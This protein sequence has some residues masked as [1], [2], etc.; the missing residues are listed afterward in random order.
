MLPAGEGNSLGNGNEGQRLTE[1]ESDTQGFVHLSGQ[2]LPACA[3]TW[4]CMIGLETQEERADVSKGV[5]AEKYRSMAVHL[6]AR[7]VK[8]H[9]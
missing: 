6:T 4:A 3:T 9:E 8:E 2:F 5:I 7:F 1:S